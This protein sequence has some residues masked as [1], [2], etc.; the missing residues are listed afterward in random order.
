VD[1]DLPLIAALKA[2]DDTAL[3]E[4]MH[5]YREPLFHFAF[6]YLGNEAVSRDVVQETFVRC[7]FKAKD[8]TPRATVKT[9]LYAIALNLCRD[10]IRRTKRRGEHSPNPSN[11]Q[12]DD[13]IADPGI[14]PTE[15][16]VR[17]ERLKLLRAAIDRL[18]RSLREALIVFSIEERSQ[19]EAAEILG[20][21]PKTIELRVYHA[22]KKLRDALRSV[23]GVE[24]FLQHEEES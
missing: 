3:D 24:F 5:R 6:R 17:E 7:Y 14:G 15:A 20:T 10:Q 18:P 12:M 21:T 9:W 8:F 4:L 1:P 11:Q 23:L 2:G 19:R 22:K 13:F 16:A